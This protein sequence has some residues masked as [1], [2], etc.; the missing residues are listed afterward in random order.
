MSCE[1][2]KTSIVKSSQILNGIGIDLMSIMID[3]SRQLTD[4]VEA[5]VVITALQISLIDLFNE[6]GIRADGYVGHSLGEIAA[7]YCDGCL[8]RKQAILSKFE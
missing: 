8:D 3:D 4:L 7:A 2:I 5:I 1:I 6:L